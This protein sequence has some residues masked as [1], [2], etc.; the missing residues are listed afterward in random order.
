MS[1]LS[2]AEGVDGRVDEGVA[3]QQHHMQLEQRSVTFTVW[4]HGT[5][6]DDNE[7]DEKWRPTHHE[8]PKQNGESQGPSHTVA[9]PPLMPTPPPA[10]G[11]QSSDLPGMDASQHEH[12]HIE[13]ADN[14]QGDDEEDNKADHD[15]PGGEE[16]HHEHS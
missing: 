2:A 14:H 13:E 11:G 5:H 8:C 3:H 15:E 10:A 16:P 9:P 4:V 6:H 1:E 12:V 7:V